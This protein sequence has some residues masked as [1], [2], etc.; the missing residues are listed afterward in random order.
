MLATVNS[1][2]CT[3]RELTFCQGTNPCEEVDDEEK[4]L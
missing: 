4:K 3:D 1:A 2:E